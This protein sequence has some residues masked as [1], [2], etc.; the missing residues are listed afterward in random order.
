MPPPFNLERL[1]E[2]HAQAVFA[3]LLNLTRNESDTRDL[4]QEV[5]VKLAQGPELLN[6]VLEPRAFLLRIARNLAI[7]LM[8]R[9]GTRE[10]NYAV[11]AGET[12]RVF[13]PVAAPDERAF[14]EALS[15]ALGELPAEQREVVHFQ[16]TRN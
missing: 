3:F 6:G 7:D 5:F 14:Q 13:E 12:P 2:D 16:P 15:G 8:R 4:L 9:Q 10:R 11:L 1:Y